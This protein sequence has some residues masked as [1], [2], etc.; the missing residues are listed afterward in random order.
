MA[1]LALHPVGRRTDGSDGLWMLHPRSRSCRRSAC[2][3]AHGPVPVDTADRRLALHP[4]RAHGCAGPDDGASM[5]A[6]PRGTP[7]TSTT[8]SH[9]RAQTAGRHCR[10]RS[11]KGRASP[12]RRPIPGPLVPRGTP[13][14]A[15]S[16]QPSR[17]TD[18]GTP[19][20]DWVWQSGRARRW[21]TGDSAAH[22]VPPGTADMDGGELG[23]G[24]GSS[25]TVDS[26]APRFHV[27]N[28]GSSR[29]T[30]ALHPVGRQSRRQP[31]AR[32][33]GRGSGERKIETGRNGG[34][35]S[36]Q[37]LSTGDPRVA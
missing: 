36:P 18:G 11:G 15:T 21:A 3:P 32:R 26:P 14:T 13:A 7:A 12:V 16:S 17:R 28:E 24:E 25:V 27:N 1:T 37:G 20:R 9:R 19:P 22:S 23:L 6:V 4:L 31:P 2:R 35:S 5:P 33:G 30:L 34:Q 8:V 10:V 29:R